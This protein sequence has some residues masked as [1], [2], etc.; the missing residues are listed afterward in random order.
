MWVWAYFV[1]PSVNTTGSWSDEPIAV[2]APFARGDTAAVVARGPFHWPNNPNIPRS[3]FY[4]RVRASAVSPDDA[5]V[6]SSRRA[7]ATQGAVRVT[8]RR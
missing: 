4:A 8:V 2:A 3:G 7:Y 1:N 5:R 6:E